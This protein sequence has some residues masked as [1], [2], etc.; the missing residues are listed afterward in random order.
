MLGEIR[1]V[2][3]VA[4]LLDRGRIT[5]I[6]DALNRSH[7]SLRDDYE[8]SSVELDSAVEAA[9]EAGAWGAR[10]TGGGFGG[11]AIALVPADRIDAVV[12]NV[13]RRADTAGLPVPQ[14]LHAEP[15]G[16]A[17]RL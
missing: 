3:E 6:G 5:D 8:V 4:D 1:R 10:M 2:R 11:S 14:F 12:E 7:A 9:L 13:A 16:S 17:H 15:S